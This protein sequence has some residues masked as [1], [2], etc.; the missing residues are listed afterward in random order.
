MVNKTDVSDEEEKKPRRRPGFPKGVSGNPQG[1]RKGSLNK[2][3]KDMKDMLEEALEA[4]G[5]VSQRKYPRTTKGLS[6]G[7]AYLMEQAHKNP[8]A[9]MG[10]AKGLLPAKI[11][12]DVTVMNRDMVDL[13]STRREQLAELRDVTPEED[14]DA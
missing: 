14:D 13:L 7:A 11:D 12:V 2:Y 3:T 5:K 6:P 8:V 10:L 9:F 4:A 1:R